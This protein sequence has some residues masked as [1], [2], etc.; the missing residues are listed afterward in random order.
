[1]HTVLRLT[2]GATFG[3][4]LAGCTSNPNVPL[5]FAQTN[6]FGMSAHT[7]TAQGADLTLGYRGSDIAIVPVT[8]TDAYGN[9]VLIAGTGKDIG[10]A[11]S[12]FGHFGAK[13][14]SATSVGLGSFFATGVAAR[15]LAV[16]FRKRLENTPVAIPVQ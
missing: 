1:M 4:I 8:A 3:G 14:D 7:S 6:T 16:G 10:D 2:I 13:V 9:L 15:Q 12:V 5:F 11:M